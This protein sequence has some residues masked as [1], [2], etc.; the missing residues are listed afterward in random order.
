MLIVMVIFLRESFAPI[1]LQRKAYKIRYETKNWA[2]RSKLDEREFDAKE[3]LFVYALRPIKSAFSVTRWRCHSLTLSSA[4]RRAHPTF[5]YPLHLFHL[6]ASPPSASTPL[7]LLTEAS[8]GILYLLFGAVPIEFRGNRGY[9]LGNASLPFISVFIGA[10]IACGIVWAFA[11][12]YARVLHQR[13]A[14]AVPEERCLPMMI[15]AVR[16]R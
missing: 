11:P 9:S 3:I 4:R 16:A 15:G 7:R 6:C 13:K 2:I 12:R 5:S 10:V 1:L 14:I 8:Q